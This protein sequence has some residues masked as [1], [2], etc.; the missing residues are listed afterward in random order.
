M[1]QIIYMS[2]AS[3]S[4]TDAE[5]AQ[6][7]RQAQQGNER[8]GITGALVY[9]N[10]QFMQIMEG[11]QA[12]L[13]ELY[14]QLGQD[15]RHQ[16]LFKLA[17]RPIPVRRFSEWSMGFQVVS[18]AAFEQLRGYVAPAQMA[19]QLPDLGAADSLFI[20]RMRDLILAFKS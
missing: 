7:L 6:L 12:A 20:D 19:Q 18:P 5:L 2:T 3:W 15:R 10:G 13:E 9:S 14:A 4:M 11:E 16:G 8:G 1:H 17:D